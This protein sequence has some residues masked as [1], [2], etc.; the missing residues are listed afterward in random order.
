LKAWYNKGIALDNINRHDEA[1]EAYNKA[2]DI[3]PGYYEA[4]YNKWLSLA[5][6]GRHDEAL[7]AY[8]KA[9]QCR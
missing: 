3:K 8:E 9:N 4:W 2:I 5:I 6:V 1:I 7:E